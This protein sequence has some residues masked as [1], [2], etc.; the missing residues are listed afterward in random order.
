MVEIWFGILTVNHA[1]GKCDLR[2]YRPPT[3]YGSVLRSGRL[4][5]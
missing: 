1:A 2:H 3:D 4:V 5:G